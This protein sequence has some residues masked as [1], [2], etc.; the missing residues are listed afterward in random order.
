LTFKWQPDE[1]LGSG[2]G[3]DIFASQHHHL[4]AFDRFEEY[5]FELTKAVA[6]D[7]DANR[8]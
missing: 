7:F 6:E 5:M 1:L 2:S 3:L 4:Q 8:V